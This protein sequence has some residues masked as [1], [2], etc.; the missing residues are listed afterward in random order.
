MPAVFNLTKSLLADRRIVQGQ[1][2][3]FTLVFDSEFGLSWEGFY[4]K[5]A[6]FRRDHR[7]TGE[8][9]LF[10]AEATIVA[11]GPLTRAIQFYVSPE[12]TDE[13]FA[14]EGRWDCEITND[15]ITFR[16]V[17]GRFNLNR[18]VTD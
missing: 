5:P 14:E 9:V 12:S 2:N 16:V 15:I 6:Q 8:S 7:S 18:Q 4:A 3:Y 13:V 17:N 11:F 10:E 1:S